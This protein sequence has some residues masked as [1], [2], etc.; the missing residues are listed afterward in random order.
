M[1][2]RGARGTLKWPGGVAQITRICTLT[3]PLGSIGAA[4]HNGGY[5]LVTGTNG[6]HLG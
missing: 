6:D 4:A 2:S 3:G 5:S 1:Q